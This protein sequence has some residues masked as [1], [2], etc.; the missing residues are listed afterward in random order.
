VGGVTK[1][2]ASA[3]VDDAPFI[4]VG[5]ASPFQGRTKSSLGILMRTTVHLSPFDKPRGVVNERDEHVRVTWNG[6]GDG[7]VDQAVTVPFSL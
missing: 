1:F 6:P 5:S 3:D 4:L 2:L 7:G